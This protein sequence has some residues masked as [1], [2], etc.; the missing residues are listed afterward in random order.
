M[1]FE[2][3][4]AVDKSFKPFTVSL[5]FETENEAREFQVRMALYMGSC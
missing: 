1:E 3:S 2:F 4:P 5:T